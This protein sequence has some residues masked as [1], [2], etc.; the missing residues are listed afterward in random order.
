MKIIPHQNA[1]SSVVSVT[2]S[3]ANV[4]ALINTAGSVSDS[5]QYFSTQSLNSTGVGNGFVI[6]PEDGDVRMGVG[7]TP[8][9][10][11][12]ILL[13]SGT[14]Y[15]FPN[16]PLEEVKLIRA[17]SSNVSC[18][19]EITICEDDEPY[20]AVAEKVTVESTEGGGGSSSGGGLVDYFARPAGTPGDA[21]SAYASGTTLT[22]TGLPYAFGALN[23]KSIDRYNSSNVYQ[24]TYTPKTDTITVSSTTITVSGASF[25]SGDLFEVTLSLPPKTINTANDTQKVEITNGLD[26]TPSWN[27]LVDETNLA[28]GTYAYYITNDKNAINC[29]HYILNDGSGT[30][31][32]KI[33]GS[34]EYDAAI[35]SATYEEV[36]QA[37]FN[38]A[39][40]TGT[41]G[42][43]ILTD[44]ARVMAPY[45]YTKV[46]VVTSTGGADDGDATIYHGK[47]F[48]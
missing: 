45:K 17:G 21:V 44:S 8:T 12:G 38:Q 43:G 32:M 22:V 14:K 35:T 19:I 33:Y 30:T 37:V 11:L 25:S 13:S 46:E 36:T 20:T 42:S 24:D 15:S 39:S 23:I 28:D 34:L 5:Q 7:I 18:S 1:S 2:S 6:T 31:T 27:K 10:S 9:A 40:F 29:F 16:I 41:D 48:I 4:F 26:T 47:V 3:A